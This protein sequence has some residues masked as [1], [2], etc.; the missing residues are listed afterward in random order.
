MAALLLTLGEGGAVKNIN[1]G[2]LEVKPLISDRQSYE[3]NIYLTR[4]APKF[5]WINRGELGVEFADKVD[6]RLNR[7]AIQSFISDALTRFADKVGS[8]LRLTGGYT[9]EFLSYSRDISINN[10]THHMANLAVEASLPQNVTATIKD[11][12]VQTTDQ[13]TSELPTLT[14]RMQN[15]AE[16]NMAAPLRGKLG[17]NLAAQHTYNNYL[18]TTFNMLDRQEMLVGGDVT[19]RVQPKTQLVLGYRYGVMSYR[20]PSAKNGDSFYNNLDLG[21]T[22]Y[23]T[24]KLV[25]TVK[26]GVQYRRYTESLNQARDRITTPGYS[27]QL[28]WQPVELTD[29]IIYGKRSNVET[30]VDPASGNSR[31]YTSTM[32]DIALS[33]QVHKINA[34]LGFNYESI[35]YAESTAAT[36][37]KRLDAYSSVRLTAEYNRQKWFRATAGY[38]LKSRVSNNNRFD[39][40]DDIISLELKGL[41]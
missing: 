32:G 7:T 11:S 20:V 25:G 40:R 13:A 12:Y 38:I 9:M 18:A 21:I 30:S 15:I 33:R 5:A 22:G 19:Y 1:F 31:F 36:G 2:T 17:F 29:I 34:G 16:L 6:S 37:K 10:V 3:S 39:Y 8:R 35:T 24:Q 14:H 27:L 4:N 28:A 26:A 41:F 23:I